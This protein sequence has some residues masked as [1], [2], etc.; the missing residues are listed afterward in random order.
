VSRVVKVREQ[1]DAFDAQSEKK[2]DAP[3]MIQTISRNHKMTVT[4]QLF[5]ASLSVIA[6]PSCTPCS[7]QPFQSSQSSP[8][9]TSAVSIVSVHITCV[10]FAQLPSLQLETLSLTRSLL[11]RLRSPAPVALLCLGWF[12]SHLL[13]LPLESIDVR[14]GQHSIARVCSVPAT[15][16]P[17]VPVHCLWQYLRR[18][19]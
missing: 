3:D 19:S 5:R 15:L 11:L 12:V 16:A 18:L 9:C 4:P 13:L 7:H 17:V 14:L 1:R 10:R 2:A 8:S 6:T